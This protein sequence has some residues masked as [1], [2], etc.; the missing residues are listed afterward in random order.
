MF[1]CSTM[2][3]LIPLIQ[4]FKVE[5][6]DFSFKSLVLVLAVLVGSVQL[7]H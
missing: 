1:I 6:F 7:G 3:F 5:Y 2:G 4:S